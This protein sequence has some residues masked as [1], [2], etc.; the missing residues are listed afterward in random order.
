MLAYVLALAVGL[1]SLTIYLAAFFFPEVH[2]KNDFIWSGLGLFYA[3]VLWVCAGRIT[4]SLLLGQVASVVLLSWSVGQTLSLRRQITPSA[5]TPLPST[6]E[7]KNTV[8]EKVSNSSLFGKISQIG[9]RVG[10]SATAAKDRLQENLSGTNQTPTSSTATPE[11][12]VS[13]GDNSK[14]QIIDKRTPIAEQPADISATQQL[15]SDTQAATDTE[16]VIP[17][18]PPQP[19]E[20][21]QAARESDAAE[22][23]QA[24]EVAPVIIEELVAE[25][26]VEIAPLL[27][28]EEAI[29]LAVEITLAD[30]AEQEDRGEVVTEPMRPHPP[31]PE[32]VEAAILDAEEKHIEAS[33]PEPD[34]PENPSPS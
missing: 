12:S 14:V 25:V 7:V 27:T 8:G 17:A 29:A 13:N 6:A 11:A 30:D 19:D 15:T 18:N 22:D 31:D 28:E 4:G 23:T 20:L 1:G 5:Q 3:L 34:T 21:V 24:V 32:I 16:Q 2:R 33:P 10:G 9:K 26:D